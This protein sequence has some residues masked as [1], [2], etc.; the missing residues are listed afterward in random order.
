M[1]ADR[2]GQHL[3]ANVDLDETRAVQSDNPGNQN[4]AE[5]ATAQNCPSGGMR[6]SIADPDRS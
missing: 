5:R 6:I 2:V 1:I 4:N 3:R